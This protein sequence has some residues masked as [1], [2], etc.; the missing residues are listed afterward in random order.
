MRFEYRIAS[1]V[2]SLI[3]LLLVSLLV[4]TAGCRKDK[5]H[6]PEISGFTP[7]SGEI[8]DVLT[9]TGKNFSTNASQ[10]IVNINGIAAVVTSSTSTQIVTTVPEGA[11]TGRISV[12]R[13]GLTG[14]SAT[15]FTVI[16]I[17]VIPEPAITGFS[18]DSGQVGDT[19]IITGTN[20][21]T[22]PAENG[23]KF[24]NTLAVVTASTAIQITTTVPEGASTGKITVTVGESSAVS[25]AD[26]TVNPPLTQ[27]VFGGQY[28]DG[29]GNTLPCYWTGTERVDLPIGSNTYGWA[30]SPTVVVGSTV[31]AAGRYYDNASGRYVPCYWDGSDSPHALPLPEDVFSY[32]ITGIAVSNGT[33]YTL[34]FYNYQFDADHFV[35]VPCIW[36]NTEN[37]QV[38]T[39]PSVI[40]N[41]SA[42]AI[43]VSD[44]TTYVTGKYLDTGTSDYKACYW[45]GT[46]L[47]DLPTP[48]I[49]SDIYG[50]GIAVSGGTVYVSG[51]YIYYDNVT[52]KKAC[53]WVDDEL[54]ILDSPEGSISEGSYASSI[55]VSGGEVYV[56]GNYWV[57][58]VDRVCYWKSGELKD[59]ISPAGS[60]GQYSSSITV[61]DDTVYIGGGY[62]YMYDFNYYWRAGYWTDEG[63][64]TPLNDIEQDS[65]INSSMWWWD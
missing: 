64:I 52:T 26:F 40:G 5:K 31:Y 46:T 50:T 58:A 24:N 48:A 28:E 25:S 3:M 34:G 47:V 23:V 10:N 56:S 15:D 7:A 30:L 55:A 1:R 59:V 41:A 54:F 4:L 57:D 63:S 45:E 18:P 33:V 2:S 21:S 19:V 51:T 11:T 43:T 27:P 53:Y 32:Q 37:P 6:P 65:F 62:N 35:T 14:T 12:T 39:D 29:D 20:F 22:T 49:A 44:G 17:P 16:S 8:G 61:I 60:I 13:N 36:T 9:I 42:Y 38:L